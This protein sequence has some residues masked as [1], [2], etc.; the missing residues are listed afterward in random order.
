MLHA[1]ERRVE[2]VI[3]HPISLSGSNIRRSLTL[4]EIK[5]HL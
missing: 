1:R 2:L 5:I 3:G 4:T